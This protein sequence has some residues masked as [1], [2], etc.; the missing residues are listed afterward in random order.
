M[1]AENKYKLNHNIEAL[2]IIVKLAPGFNT[3]YSTK[4]GITRRHRR[5]R[6]VEAREG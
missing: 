6:H 5:H 3:T 2:G 4:K 1:Q